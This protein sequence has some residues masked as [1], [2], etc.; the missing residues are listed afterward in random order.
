MCYLC[1][2]VIQRKKKKKWTKYL[3]TWLKIKKVINIKNCKNILLFSNKLKY[4]SIL[5]KQ[6]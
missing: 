1:Y 5:L 3:G 6:Y 4:N 2:V